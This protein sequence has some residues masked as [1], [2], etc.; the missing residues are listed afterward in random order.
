MVFVPVKP[1]GTFEHVH[2]GKDKWLKYCRP[3]DIVFGLPARFFMPTGFFQDFDF[4]NWHLVTM[5]F[6]FKYHGHLSTGALLSLKL[7]CCCPSS[8]DFRFGFASWHHFI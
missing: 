5:V 2:E 1:L 7:Y 3:I 8:Y 4:D 6:N